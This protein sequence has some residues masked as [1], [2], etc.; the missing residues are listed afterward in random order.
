MAAA[1]VVTVVCIITC[2]AV[3]LQA[4]TWLWRVGPARR[5][6][7]R[8][9]PIAALVIG[10]LVAHVVEIGVNAV[11]LV[12][13]ATVDGDTR[14][15]REGLEH[16]RLEVWYYSAC[17]YTSLGVERNPPTAGLRLFTTSEALLG[18]ILITWTASFLFLLMQEAWVPRGGGP[19]TPPPDRAD[20]CSES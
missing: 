3:H 5:A 18:L 9:V 12:L 6:A 2:V 1:I 8:P 16:E 7:R 17:F 14:L 15:A 4:L 20:L 13:I 10:C 19:G 11:G